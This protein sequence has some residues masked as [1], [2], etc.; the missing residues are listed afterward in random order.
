[1]ETDSVSLL[2]ELLLPEWCW[3]ERESPVLLM[4]VSLTA[5]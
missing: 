5:S 3:L 4:A 2:P 1:L